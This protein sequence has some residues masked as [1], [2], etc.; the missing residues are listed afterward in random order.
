MKEIEL[1]KLP[2]AEDALAPVISPATVSF[3]HG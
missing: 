1:E 3:H 2:Y